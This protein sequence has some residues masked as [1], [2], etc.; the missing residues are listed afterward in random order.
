MKTLLLTMMV[1]ENAVLI[2]RMTRGTADGII[3]TYQGIFK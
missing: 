2:G 1:L 3:E